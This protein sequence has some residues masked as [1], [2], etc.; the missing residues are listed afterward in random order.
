MWV[1]TAIRLGRGSGS[2]RRDR[3]GDRL[4]VVAVLDALGVPA[5]G[6]EPPDD[7]LRP[8]HRRRP[9]EL[10]VVVVVEG[11]ELAEP[12]MAGER[13]GLGRDALLEVAVGAERVR[14]V[15]DDVVAGAVELGGEAALGDRHAD[16]VREPLAERPGRRL[17]AGR[18][19]VLR[20]ARASSSR[21][22]GTTSGRR[23]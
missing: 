15:V 23:A 4:D 22:A 20:V 11:D 7:V 3:L 16:G 6:V 9:V 19:A 10:D 17:D 18:Q 14:P 5:V 1:R 12:E 8:G 21:T 2:G 13:R